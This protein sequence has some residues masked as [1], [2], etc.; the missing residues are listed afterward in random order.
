M[1]YNLPHILSLP[2]SLALPLYLCLYLSILHVISGKLI[3][4]LVPI[5]FP[6]MQTEHPST[7]TRCQG[8]NA[9]GTITVISSAAN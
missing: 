8:Q 1:Q 6:T 5:L 4:C 2:C 9:R 3:S 7:W